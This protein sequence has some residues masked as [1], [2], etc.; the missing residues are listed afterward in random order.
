MMGEIPVGQSNKASYKR[1]LDIIAHE[2]KL[3]E[4]ILKRRECQE[5]IAMEKDQV[6]KDHI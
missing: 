6:L 2:R 1:A 4:E 5:K 3:K